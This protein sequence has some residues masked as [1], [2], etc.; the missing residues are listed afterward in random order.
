MGFAGVNGD[1]FVVSDAAGNQIPSSKSEIH[2]TMAGN[3]EW[4]VVS[5][6]VRRTTVLFGPTFSIK[7][8]QS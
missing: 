2:S 5:G 3:A 7:H 6:L 4:H 1:V 8:I